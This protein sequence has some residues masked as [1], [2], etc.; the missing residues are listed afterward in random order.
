ML[1]RRLLIVL[2]TG[3][4]AAQTAAAQPPEFT[5]NGDWSL[6]VPQVSFVEQ[7]PTWAIAD[8]GPTFQGTTAFGTEAPFAYSVI[9]SGQKVFGSIYYA[10][11]N[12]SPFNIPLAADV[13]P[14]PIP[15]VKTLFVLDGNVIRG[16]AVQSI[17]GKLV[18]VYL[19]N[20]GRQVAN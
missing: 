2:V 3:M 7:T 4:C 14:P 12:F 10:E 8:A 15:T 5:L 18:S 11:A 9:L 6:N 20:G 13:P 19:V 1:C 17:H 16:L